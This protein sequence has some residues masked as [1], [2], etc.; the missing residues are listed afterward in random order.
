MTLFTR[1]R[2]SKFTL[3]PLLSKY[4]ISIRG[5]CFYFICFVGQKSGSFFFVGGG[6]SKYYFFLHT[7]RKFFITNTTKIPFPF[8]VIS[9]LNGI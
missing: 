3:F 2:E 9:L 7:T 6:G 8:L 1:I 5:L 4:K